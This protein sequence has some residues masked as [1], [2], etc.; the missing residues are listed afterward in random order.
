[1]NILLLAAN[2]T[3]LEPAWLNELSLFLLADDGLMS[4][5]IEE[6][7]RGQIGHGDRVSFIL[8]KDATFWLPTL[9]I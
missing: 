3:I 2:C 6:I 5:I 7:L 4:E 9:T 1:V 8:L